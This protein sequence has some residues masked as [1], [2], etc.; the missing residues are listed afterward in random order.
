MSLCNPNEGVILLDLMR[1][2]E[3]DY[4]NY[5]SVETHFLDRSIESIMLKSEMSMNIQ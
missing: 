3:E 5:F 1:R 2:A 4:Q